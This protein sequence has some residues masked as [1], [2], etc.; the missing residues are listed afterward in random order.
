MLAVG[1]ANP[2]LS[3]SIVVDVPETFVITN[4]ETTFAE[5]LALGAIAEPPRVAKNRKSDVSPEAMM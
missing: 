5:P 4:A 2:E 3:Q 1:K